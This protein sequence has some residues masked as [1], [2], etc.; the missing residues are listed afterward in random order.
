MPVSSC[1]VALK[2]PCCLLCVLEG[3]VQSVSPF[4]RV[5]AAPALPPRTAAEPDRVLL[6]PQCLILNTLITSIALNDDSGRRLPVSPTVISLRTELSPP[7]ALHPRHPALFPP[8]S[9]TLACSLS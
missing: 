8:H 2:P 3:T 7:L 5:L 4:E 6:C 9:K 1:S